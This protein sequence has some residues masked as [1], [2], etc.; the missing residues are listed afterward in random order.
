MSITKYLEDKI[1]HLFEQ[2]YNLSNS[3]LNVSSDQKSKA[4]TPDLK[5]LKVKIVGWD[6]ENY[7]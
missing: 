1:V 3:T 7:C 2:P 5:G 4:E 6:K